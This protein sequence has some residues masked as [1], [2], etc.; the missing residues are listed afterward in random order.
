MPDPEHVAEFMCQHV[1]ESMGSVVSLRSL[2]CIP[3]HFATRV[4]SL[5][6]L[7]LAHLLQLEIRYLSP[8][9][10]CNVINVVT[11]FMVSVSDR[12]SPSRLQ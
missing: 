9:V 6:F 3:E 5:S 2:P 10:L 7:W 1:F 8:S 11:E 12:V 4:L